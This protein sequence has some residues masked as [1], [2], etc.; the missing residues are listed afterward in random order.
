MKQYKQKIKLTKNQKGFTLIEMII[1]VSIFVLVLVIAANIYLVINN[2]QR[3]V[4]TMQRIQSDT[5]YLFE[6]IAQEIRLGQINYDFYNNND[7]D[8]H[9][10]AADNTVLAVV[11]R[12][13]NSVFFKLSSIGDKVQYC[14]VNEE[15]NC[16]LDDD[17]LWQNVT[18]EGVEVEHLRFIITPSADPF[19]EVSERECNND[20]D[21]T[22]DYIS[23]R[24]DIGGD[25]RCE[26]YSDGH[27]FQPK[28]QIVLKVRG[29]ARSIAEESEMIMQTIVSSRI[30]PGKVQNNN[31][32]QL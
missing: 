8:I 22:G 28:V 7:I 31:Y 12:S 32:D 20:S 27:N 14:E 3:K 13:G 10:S 1:S 29:T 11:N 30:M 6:A 21:C 23:Y 2:T 18:P 15:N 9:P 19:S 24:C 16:A 25:D 17:S 4:V 26:Y 5:R